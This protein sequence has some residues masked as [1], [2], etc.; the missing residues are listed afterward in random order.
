M[1]AAPILMAEIEVTISGRDVI[2]ATRE[3]P[4][5]LVP[6]PVT[7]EI[8]SAART[9]KGQTMPSTTAAP[10]KPSRPTFRLGISASSSAVISVETAPFSLFSIM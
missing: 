8:V 7:S 3:E 4:T 5:K 2:S 1:S 10:R 6:S 9:M